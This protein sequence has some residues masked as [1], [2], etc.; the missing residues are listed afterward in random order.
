MKLQIT[1]KGVK[2]SRRLMDLV[3]KK[4]G[5]VDRLLSDFKEDT[6]LSRVK[7]SKSKRWGYKVKYS[8]KLPGKTK[9]YAQEKGK[10]LESALTKL[11]D[12]VLRQTRQYKRKLQ[13]Y[14]KG[15]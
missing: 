15:S 10:T 4:L 9:I 6:K 1:G 7:I 8:M 11:K 3:G 12:N 13:D 5:K 2:V 14:R